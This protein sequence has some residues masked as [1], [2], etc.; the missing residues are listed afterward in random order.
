ME[1]YLY[2]ESKKRNLEWYANDNKPVLHLESENH[3]ARA[4]KTISRLI[5]SDVDHRSAAKYVARRER[6]Y[7]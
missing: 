4:E 7:R 6:G 2:G 5:D 3:Y 1:F